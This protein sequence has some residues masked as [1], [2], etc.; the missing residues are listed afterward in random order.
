MEI[1]RNC[2]GH[3]KVMVM[4]MM[5]MMMKMMIAKMVFIQQQ[6]TNLVCTSLKPHSHQQN[7]FN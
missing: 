2:L 1:T 4:M 7:M 3:E 6:V 5:T